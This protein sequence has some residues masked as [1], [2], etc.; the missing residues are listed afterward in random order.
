MSDKKYVLDASALLAV[1]LGEA[2]G[3]AVH[4]VLAQA[5]IGAVNLSEVV[6]K[7]QE[8]GVPDEVIDLSLADLDVSV[9]PFDRSQAVRAGKL[10]TA[11]RSA[12]L[13]LG[14]RACL[15]TAA[16]LGA[17]AITTDRAWGRVSVDVDIELAR[18]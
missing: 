10:R 5:H 13:S 7:L 12:G 6:A 8:R 16:E 4:A 9:V 3:E 14:D 11:T 2:G 17:I 15:A 18:P 1:M